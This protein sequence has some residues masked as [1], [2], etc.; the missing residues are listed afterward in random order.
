MTHH[1]TIH[2]V[3]RNPWHVSLHING[4]TVEFKI[5]TGADVSVV[6][7]SLLNNNIPQA[8]KKEPT[9]PRK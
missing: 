3:H 4:A 5:D 8:V 7:K 2:E 6:P 9:R 1:I